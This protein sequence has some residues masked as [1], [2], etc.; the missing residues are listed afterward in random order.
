M[1]QFVVLHTPPFLT[2]PPFVLAVVVVAVVVIVVVAVATACLTEFP[3]GTWNP[4]DDARARATEAFSR[5]PL[6]L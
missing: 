1:K 4:T 6:Q 3:V 2:P 5:S